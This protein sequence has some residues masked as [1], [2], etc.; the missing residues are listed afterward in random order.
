MCQ[1]RTGPDS[2]TSI[3]AI[4]LPVLLKDEPNPWFRVF[5]LAYWDIL[6]RKTTGNCLIRA[7]V[8]LPGAITRIQF[9]INKVRKL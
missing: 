2:L 3:Q 1:R 8:I 7:G 6:D 9:I 4:P 5:S